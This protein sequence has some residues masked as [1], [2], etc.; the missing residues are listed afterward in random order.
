M[1]KNL[2]GLFSLSCHIQNLKLSIFAKIAQNRI[3]PRLLMSTVKSLILVL[4]THPIKSQEW[5][6]LPRVVSTFYYRLNLFLS[7]PLRLKGFPFF[8]KIFH[9]CDMSVFFRLVSWPSLWFSFINNHYMVVKLF[10]FLL[11]QMTEGQMDMPPLKLCR[12]VIQI[13]IPN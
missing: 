12:S 13:N 4:Q 2:I 3:L 8:N 1:C 10:Q 6:K 5:V 9:V 7:F 11:R